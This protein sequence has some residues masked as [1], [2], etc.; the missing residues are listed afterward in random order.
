MR[1]MSVFHTPIVFLFISILAGAAPLFA[2][3]E[4]EVTFTSSERKLSEL[5]PELSILGD[6][7]GRLNTPI[8]HFEGVAGEEDEH[9]SLNDGFEI[10]EVEISLQAPL[11]PYSIAKFFIGFHGEHVHVEEAYA[12]WPA[13]PGNMQL[14]LGKF[15]TN[16]GVLNRWHPHAFPTFDQPLALANLFGEEGLSGIGGSITFLLPS[17]WADYNELII[18]VIN[19]DNGRAFSG[20]GFET[21]VGIFHLKNYYDLSRA[22]YL[23]VGLSGAAGENDPDQNDMTSIGGLDLAL[24]WVPPGR[25]KYR[26]LE[27][28]T[29]SF[30]EQRQ[31]PGGRIDTF[32]MFS[33]VDAKISRRWNGGVRLD[34]MQ[35]TL[36][37]SQRTTGVAPFI[38]YWQSEFVRLRLQ[39][40]GL[41]TEESGWDHG[42]AFQS[43]FAL[44]PHKHEKY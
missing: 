7:L 2:Q 24:V 25:E 44:G 42:I 12:E 31:T 17:L 1:S 40:T 4:E 23:E 36:D 28:R 26:S 19:G 22:T 6:F 41:H 33:Y 9:A 11:D 29:E 37:R 15:R 35:D 43:T 20:E 39:Y 16:F 34:Y 38:T 8:P 5:N 30:F 14:R 27:W 3:D 21:P 32:S 18:E 10:Q 13:L